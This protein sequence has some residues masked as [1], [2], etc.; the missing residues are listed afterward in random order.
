M[1]VGPVHAGRDL[2]ERRRI[3]R[4]LSGWV[5]VLLLLATGAG[6]AGVPRAARFQLGTCPPAKPVSDFM[7]S[8]ASFL[9]PLRPPSA[10]SLPDACLPPAQSC[11]SYASA[12]AWTAGTT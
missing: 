11:F 12:T 1:R 2:T 10:S 4:T 5:I 6:A 3:M 9:A 7:A 8:P